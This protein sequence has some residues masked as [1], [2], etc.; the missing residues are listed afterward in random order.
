[1]FTKLNAVVQW[2]KSLPN[3][4]FSFDDDLNLGAAEGIC[5]VSG[6]MFSSQVVGVS[7]NK[8]IY[9]LPNLKMGLNSMRGN[10]F[11]VSFK[12]KIYPS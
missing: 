6:R 2:L 5:Q 9:Q 1:M 3:E 10:F 7:K 12:Y 4:R 11:H 8:P